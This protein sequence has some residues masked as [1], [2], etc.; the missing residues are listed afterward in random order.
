MMDGATL[1]K[2]ALLLA[3]ATMTG[4]T[5]VTAVL[6]SSSLTLVLNI[7]LADLQVPFVLNGSFAKLPSCLQPQPSS[8]SQD[9]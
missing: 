8:A 4:A 6:E 1:L 2:V 9:W 7:S 5:A 3:S